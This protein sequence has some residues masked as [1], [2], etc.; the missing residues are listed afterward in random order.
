VRTCSRV[1]SSLPDFKVWICTVALDRAFLRPSPRRWCDAVVRHGSDAVVAAVA[2]ATGGGGVH[3]VVE[4]LADANLQRDLQMLVPLG[5]AAVAVVG[6]RGDATVTP[7]LLMGRESS[8]HG[9]MLSGN[10]DDEWA[11]ARAPARERRARGAR[12]GHRARG[13]RAGQGG[14]GAGLRIL[15]PYYDTP[16]LSCAPVT[17]DHHLP[18]TAIGLAGSVEARFKIS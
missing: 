18:V 16:R 1:A 15:A 12:G 3:Y 9:V 6:S 8:V 11:E 10:T 13:R 7:R 17:D 14:A 4:M 5:H 2:A